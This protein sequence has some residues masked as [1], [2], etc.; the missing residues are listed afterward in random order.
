MKARK[1]FDISEKQSQVVELLGTHGVQV[2]QLE[3]SRDAIPGIV[4]FAFKSS[5]N[6][7]TVEVTYVLVKILSTLSVTHLNL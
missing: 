7:T 6:V 2:L 5:L 4:H 1:I 3:I